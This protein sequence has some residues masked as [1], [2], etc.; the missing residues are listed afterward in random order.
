MIV[1][2]IIS[3]LRKPPRTLDALPRIGE[4]VQF[5][6]DGPHRPPKYKVVRVHWVIG[7]HAEAHVFLKP[8]WTQL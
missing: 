1:H 2:F 5:H 4:S 8:S 3:G 7:D 6:A